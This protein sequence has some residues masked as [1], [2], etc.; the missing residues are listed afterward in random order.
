MAFHMESSGIHVEPM[1]NPCGINHS[2]LIPHGIHDVHGIR[3]WLSPQPTFIPWIPYG[4]HDG[5]HGFHM[6][7]IRNNPGKVKTS[8]LV[9]GQIVS[10][11]RTLIVSCMT[12]ACEKIQEV[13]CD[14]IRVSCLSAVYMIEGMSATGVDQSTESTEKAQAP[15]SS[16]PITQ[17]L[18]KPWFVTYSRFFRSCATSYTTSPKHFQRR[19]ASSAPELAGHLYLSYKAFT[20]QKKLRKYYI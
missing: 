18:T 2:I 10:N 17:N 16:S 7:S 1:W 8:K 3:K 5:F 11:S 12:S 13:K 9:K 19:L 6:D 20:V 15:G 14:V 4:I